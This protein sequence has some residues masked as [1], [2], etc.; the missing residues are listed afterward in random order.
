VDKLSQYVDQ[1]H[2]IYNTKLR[3]IHWSNFLSDYYH[4]NDN[5]GFCL[6][7]TDADK[8]KVVLVVDFIAD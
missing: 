4:S 6:K 1:G 2:H 8:V 5:K 3:P 7:I